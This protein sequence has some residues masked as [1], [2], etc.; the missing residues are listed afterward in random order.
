MFSRGAWVRLGGK[1]PGDVF[2]VPEFKK[3]HERAVR[4]IGLVPSRANGTRPH[5]HR[6]DYGQRLVDAGVSP[7]VVRKCMHHAS[8]SSQLVYTQPDRD[9]MT[10][11]L[12]QAQARMAAGSKLDFAQLRQK[13]LGELGWLEGHAS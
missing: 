11:E 13:Y 3:A 5:G 12:D 8:L 4:R 2:T 9:R 1:S 10:K 6:H 7:R